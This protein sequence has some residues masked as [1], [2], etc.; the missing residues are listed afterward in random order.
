MVARSYESRSCHQGQVV[1]TSTKSD[2]ICRSSG[3]IAVLASLLIAGGLASCGGSTDVAPAH[4]GDREPAGEPGVAAEALGTVEG[5]PSEDPGQ[6]AGEAPSTTAPELPAPDA[7]D[8]PPGAEPT[9]IADPGA[10]PEPIEAEPAASV[11]IE[12]VTP[13]GL[14]VGVSA[15]FSSSTPGHDA[16]DL[17]LQYQSPGGGSFSE[18]MARQGESHTLSVALVDTHAPELKYTIRATG[19]GEAVWPASGEPFV[20]AV[21]PASAVEAAPPPEPQQLVEI[22]YSAGEFATLGDAYRFM[23][24]TPGFSDCSIILSWRTAAGSWNRAQMSASGESHSYS[25]TPTTEMQPHLQYYFEVSA[26]GQG[27]HPN[28]GNLTLPVY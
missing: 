20:V 4:P 6:P 17:E 22:K 8:E 2:G 21:T 11:V 19:C 25:L 12:H 15:S 16:C 9:D 14:A 3:L 7:T 23:C 27:R 18:K 5:S 26:C 13:S 24:R 28:S 1:L 10:T